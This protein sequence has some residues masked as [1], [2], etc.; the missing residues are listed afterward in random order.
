[1]SI[2]LGFFAG[3]QIGRENLFSNQMEEHETFSF[4]L[5]LKQGNTGFYRV[6]AVNCPWELKIIIKCI[7]TDQEVKSRTV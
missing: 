7:L 5:Q 6:S 2:I 4:I 3:T 1:M